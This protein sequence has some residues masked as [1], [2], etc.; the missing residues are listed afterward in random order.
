MS[1]SIYLYTG[2]SEGRNQEFKSLKNRLKIDKRFQIGFHSNLKM[3]HKRKNEHLNHS[4]SQE[5]DKMIESLIPMDMWLYEFGKRLFQARWNFFKTG[6]Y[7]QP[8][9]PPYPGICPKEV[10]PIALRYGDPI[11]TGAT[12]LNDPSSP[13]GAVL[14]CTSEGC[15]KRLITTSFRYKVLVNS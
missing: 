13:R 4:S 8:N 12:R 7:I 9:H 6:I 1:I 11:E 15:Q 5:I 3:P 2:P 10:Y 14:S